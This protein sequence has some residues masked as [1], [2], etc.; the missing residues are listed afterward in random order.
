VRPPPDSPLALLDALDTA[1]VRTARVGL[2]LPWANVAVET[3]LPRLGLANTTFHSARLVPASKNTAIGGD[4]WDELS[5]AA[6]D[7]VDSLSR[8]PLDGVLLACTSA[9]FAGSSSPPS[10]VTTAFDTLV[11]ALLA[12]NLTQVV[13]A[14]PYPA[15]ITHAENAALARSG[16]TVLAEASLGLVDGYPDVTADQVHDLIDQL[17]RS[18][19][20]AA[21][22]VVLSCTGW[23]TLSVI[24]GLEHRLG[25]PVLSSNLAMGLLAARIS[26]GV[27]A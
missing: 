14:T 19:M 23:H 5:T 17:P 8:I 24:P 20:R 22:A 25:R 6:A 12:S 21:D 1:A 13:L 16:V 9:G 3:E 11:D 2:L 10:G 7:A 15:S 27:A 4:F 18:A 26:A